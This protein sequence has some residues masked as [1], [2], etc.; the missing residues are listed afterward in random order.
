MSID[1]RKKLCSLMGG[2]GLAALSID[3]RIKA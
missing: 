3:G 2:T 1:G